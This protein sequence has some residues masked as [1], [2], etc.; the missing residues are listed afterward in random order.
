MDLFERED[1]MAVL[2]REARLAAGGQPRVVLVEGAAGMGRTSLVEEFAR[3]AGRDG[4]LVLHARCDEA[5]R[6]VPFGVV[7]QLFE[8]VVAEWGPERAERAFAGPA[9]PATRVLSTVPHTG[10]AVAP[11]DDPLPV[12]HGFY[13]L[14]LRI[15]A[16]TPV[17]LVVDDAQLADAPSLRW[18]H[19]LIRKLTRSRVLV[20]LTHRGDETSDPL[21]ALSLAANCRTL[22][23]EPLTE[24]AVAG[25]LTHVWD[26]DPAPE[27]ARSCHRLTGGNP[28]LLR[29]LVMA[30]EGGRVEAAA[31]SCDEL[32]KRTVFLYAEFLAD[33]LTGLRPRTREFAV[34]LALLGESDDAGTPARL[35]GLDDAQGYLA[36]DQ[37][38]RLGLLTH[39]RELRWT[40]PL[41]REALC[42]DLGGPRR[43]AWHAEAARL[44]FDDGASLDQVCDHLVPSAPSTD[45]WVAR[46][47]IAAADQ[48]VRQGAPESAARC[49]RRALA[50]PLSPDERTTVRMRLGLAESHL[51]PA[52]AI[53]QLTRVID[54]VTEPSSKATVAGALCAVLTRVGRGGEVIPLLDR[55]ADELTPVDR[56]IS[57]R[58]QGLRIGNV[59]LSGTKN[60]PRAELDR[61]AGELSGRTPG[62]RAVLAP[63]A[64]AAALSGIP[65]D[66]VAALAQRALPQTPE[67][68]SGHL[69]QGAVFAL[70]LTDRLDAADRHCDA[71][72]RESQR[73][74]A[75]PGPADLVDTRSVIA[76]LAGRLD[77]AARSLEEVSAQ[78]PPGQ[79]GALRTAPMAVRL[80]VLNE[81]GDTEAAARMAA[82]LIAAAPEEADYLSS[83]VRFQCARAQVA[84]G[85]ARD[86]L[87]LMLSAGR[88][89]ASTGFENPVILPWRIVSAHVHAE[90]GEYRAALE[91]AEEAL[92]HARRWGTARA[93]GAALHALGASTGGG[94]GMELLREAVEVLKPSPARLEFANALLGLGAAQTRH[95]RLAAA[96]VT[97]TDCL[98]EAERCGALGVAAAARRGLR[99]AGARPRTRRATGATALTEGER[100][101]ADRAAAGETNR[102]IAERL[103]LTTR[104]V[105]THLSAVYRKLGISGRGELH[106]TLMAPASERAPSERAG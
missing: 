96:R 62:E 77:D 67:E 39:A 19:Y 37:L 15:A 6:E 70:A 83:Y 29:A 85:N 55:L 44:L 72:L 93:L 103:H 100:R 23:P 106:R 66:Q 41:V 50:E 42:R 99:A 58:L 94:R 104:T 71:A 28:L 4:A 65:A 79:W 31:L 75:L 9:E 20:V 12:L 64:L 91:L 101:V 17:V 27:L 88:R 81:R 69:G 92:E 51:R 74:H 82:E 10:A 56:E 30:L 3:R 60:V 32:P 49:L 16:V 89:L 86:G 76:L 14:T 53:R 2:E 40:H 84:Q 57:L 48:A 26:Q 52:A 45:P 25:L 35:A 54:D 95:G 87:D 8:P 47:L 63:C 22:R 24:A 78:L 68:L 11:E 36:E 105:E 97:F 13:W 34:A 33:W 5:E 102:A 46:T 73:A 80:T 7:R 21:T 90:L 59:L 38:R 98:V 18:I 43:A 61:M 1:E